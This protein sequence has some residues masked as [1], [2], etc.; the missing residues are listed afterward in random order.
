MAWCWDG[1]LFQGFV[2]GQ[3]RLNLRGIR[4]VVGGVFGGV[5]AF[6]MELLNKV[7]SSKQ[8]AET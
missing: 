3:N 4:V 6:G 8:H 1:A 5:G 2:D 7:D